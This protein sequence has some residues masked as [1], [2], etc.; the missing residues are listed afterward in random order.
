MNRRGFIRG[1]LAGCIAPAVFL[2]I[3]KDRYR[4]VVEQKRFMELITNSQFAYEY[5]F[6]WMGYAGEWRFVMDGQKQ[7]VDVEICPPL[8]PVVYKQANLVIRQR[9]GQSA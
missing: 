1:F 7:L 4:W 9:W 5:G 2:P 6:D 8:P 3:A